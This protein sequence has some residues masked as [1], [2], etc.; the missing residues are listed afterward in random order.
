MDSNLSKTQ[1]QDEKVMGLHVFV[2]TQAFRHYV[3]YGT[4]RVRCGRPLKGETVSDR[5]F[6]VFHNLEQF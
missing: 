6:T 5:F 3:G 2:V 4:A 1:E